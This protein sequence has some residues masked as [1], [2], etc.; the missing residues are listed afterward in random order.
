M[1]APEP[2]REVEVARDGASLRDYL[3]VLRRRKW[4]LLQAV[5]LVPAIAVALSTRQS[6]V[7]Q[8]DA[9]VLLTNQTFAGLVPN[10]QGVANQQPADRTAET[11]AE[12][13]R[14]PAVVSKALALVP[15][16]GLT[17]SQF[18][19]ASSVTSSAN[20]DL[21]TFAV[22]SATPSRAAQLTSAYARA[23]TAYR[24]ELDTTSLQRA[25]RDV[26]TRIDELRANNRANS[27]LAGQL[28]AAQ[29]Q[30]QTLE[31][32]QT[33]NATVVKFASGASQISPQPVRNGLL[34]LALGLILGV[35]LVFLVDALDTRVRSGEEVAHRLRIPLLGRLAEPPKRV[36]EHHSLVMLDEP[37]G[38][39]AEAFRMLRTNLELANIEQEAK[40]IAIASGLPTEGKS[41]TIANLAV[42]VARGGHRVA[43]VDLDLRKPTLARFFGNDAR[44]GITDV[45]LGRVALEHAVL[46][47]DV[48]DFLEE[49]NGAGG[50]R[51]SNL[52]V[53]VAGQPPPNPGE[54]VSS[55]RLAS[56]LAELRANYDFV[57]IDTPPMLSVGDALAL[58][59]H[60]DA[61]MLVTNLRLS[62]RG[63]LD[64]LRRTLTFARCDVL[65]TVLTAAGATGTHGYGNPY[66]GYGGAAYETGA[67]P[68]R[69]AVGK[70]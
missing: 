39:N 6:P 13:A 40:V 30:L 3:Q 48:A 38:Q 37:H 26:G 23:Y 62:R 49:S 21:L 10:A 70:R 18:L 9:K 64:E 36:R 63:E 34:G 60:I 68:V 20:A 69:P 16:S 41:T 24:H 15:G 31:T 4:I 22:S 28:A 7:Y 55:R 56:I 53:L 33:S 50:E 19:Q 45:A 66:Y 59:T 2:A 29:Q 32:L 17:V 51:R 14:V 52:D 27:A 44:W 11:Q 58:S 67:R 47:L 42:A 25:R 12:L 5:I 8:A 35:G 57:L 46:R 65:G 61:F 54:F 43:L 1:S